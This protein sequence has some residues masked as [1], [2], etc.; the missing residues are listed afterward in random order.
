MLALGVIQKYS[1]SISVLGPKKAEGVEMP[2]NIHQ[3]VQYG[4]K[5]F[6]FS[7]KVNA[8]AYIG[9]KCVFYF[10]RE[11]TLSIEKDDFTFDSIHPLIF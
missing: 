5:V 4:G 11:N 7:N 9:I 3:A 6:S 8:V 1:G 2:K 10:H